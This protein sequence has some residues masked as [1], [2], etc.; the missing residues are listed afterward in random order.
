MHGIWKTCLS[1]ISSKV[2]FQE[3]TGQEIWIHELS[4]YMCC[5]D[6]GAYVFQRKYELQNEAKRKEMV[7]LGCTNIC[8]FACLFIRD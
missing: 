7:F 5:Q 8:L 1:N 3:Q 6:L 2:V 4:A